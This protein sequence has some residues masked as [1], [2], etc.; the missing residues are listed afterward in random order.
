M[1]RRGVLAFENSEAGLRA[2]KRRVAGLTLLER[3]IRTMARAGL[4]SITV[5]CPSDGQTRLTPATR[6]LQAEIDFVAW[7]SA[8]SHTDPPEAHLLLWGD[9]VH[10]H[11]SLSELMEVEPGLYELIVQAGQ[12]HQAAKLP[13][14]LGQSENGPRASPE[15]GLASTGAFLC[16]PGVLTPSA[17]SS[18]GSLETLIN[19][20]VDGIRF[21]LHR[22]TK[23]LWRRVVDRSTSRSAKNML[24]GQVT[25]TTSGFISR[26]INARISIPTSKLLVE[27]GLSPHA[28]TVLFVLTT[29]LAAAYFVTLAEDYKMLLLSGV[30]WQ[31]AAI[32]DRCDGEIARVRLCESKFGAWFDTV[33]DNIAYIAAYAGLLI[34]VQRLYPNDHYY[35]GLGLSAVIALLLYLGMAYRYAIK[36]GSGSLQH[37]VRDSI[38][39]VP[40][41]EKIFIYKFMERF[42]FIAKRDFFSFFFFVTA[43]TN[44]IQATYWFLIVGLHLLV[45]AVLISQRKV[46]EGYQRNR[47]GKGDGIPA[48]EPVPIASG[49]EKTR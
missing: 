5:L 48:L 43:A 14:L 35:M 20:G 9:Y 17:L 31:F 1:I 34:G 36:T 40:A 16:A 10:H 21:E 19:E 24:F 18:Y 15:D 45:V 4:R 3:G 46:H 7:E 47:V 49:S 32:F 38:Q 33:T 41:D 44:M 2:M 27:T 30:L 39:N 11:S 23:D 6:K 26:N 37:Y 28:V 12:P 42:G 25:K 22:S 13:L 29:G 8:T